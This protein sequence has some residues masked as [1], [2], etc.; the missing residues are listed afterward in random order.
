MTDLRLER[1]AF[2]LTLERE[3]GGVA[4]AEAAQGLCDLA[5]EAPGPMKAEFGPA[6]VRLL[7]DQQPEVRCA[8][9]ALAG[10][11]LPRAEAQ[12][13]LARHVS[14]AVPRVRLEAVG[15]LADLAVPSS[16]GA[17][18]AALEDEL[19]SVRFEAARGMVELRHPAGREVL[20][21]AL[22]HPELRFRAAAAL[23]RLG[24]PSAVPSLKRVF[25][26]WFLPPFERTQLAGALALLGDADGLA[27]LFK[28]AG[29]RWSV[30]RNM[31]IELLGEVGAGGARERLLEILR[32][33]ADPSRGAAA[34]GLGHLE[35]AS[36]EPALTAV[37]DERLVPDDVRLDVAE[38]LLAL[39]TASARA[40]V[41]GLRLEDADARAELEA[42]LAETAAEES[43]P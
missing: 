8:G 38:G 36:V 3:K 34:R 28:R 31:A 30:D 42:L 13:V 5:F 27:H 25:S 11:V 32:D 37:L 24:D 40:R 14:D 9:L 22:E 4:R 41:E 15:R 10:E 2:L 23:A 6:V 20:L 16:R 29:K 17:L 35:D 19:L 7:A 12:E 18:A 21:L 43:S 39:R 1:D 26:G 33:P